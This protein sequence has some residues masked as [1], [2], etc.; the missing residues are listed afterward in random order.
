MISIIVPVYNAESYISATIDTVAGQSY[1]DW[2]L[3]LVDDCSSDRSREIIEKKIA[4]FER[5]RGTAADVG[6]L[7][8]ESIDSKQDDICPQPRI[9]L[10][11][12]THNEGA[13]AARNPRGTGPDSGRDGPRPANLLALGATLGT[14]LRQP[15]AQTTGASGGG[16][17]QAAVDRLGLSRN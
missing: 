3:L 15:H 5:S 9:R 12:K 2:E 16:I 11:S 1:R 10:I 14:G 17:G 8:Y 6:S 13:A 7:S 4:E